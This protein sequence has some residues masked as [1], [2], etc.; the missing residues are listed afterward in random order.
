MKRLGVSRQERYEQLDRPALRPLPATRFEMAEWTLSRV[1]VDYH[2]EIDRNYYSV[3]HSLLHEEVEARVT[4]TTVEVFFQGQRVASHARAVGKNRAVTE[5]SHMPREH[6]AYAEWTPERLVAW[7]GQSGPATARVVAAIMARRAH[8]EQGFR[9]CLGLMRLGRGYGAD[10]LEA[11]C[12]RAE[13]L[14]A[15]SYRT[16]ENIL[17]SGQDRVPLPETG[18]G[19]RVLP[20]HGNVRGAAYYGRKKEGA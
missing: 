11:A 15:Y 6:R 8:P 7:A 16:I 13:R 20:F 10:R 19:N 2:V 5:A 18:E 17:R 9:A 12:L 3:P 4:A 1:N 14:K